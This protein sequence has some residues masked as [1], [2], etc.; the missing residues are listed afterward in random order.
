MTV[1]FMKH[2]KNNLHRSLDFL[3]PISRFQQR[4]HQISLEYYSS[5]TPTLVNSLVDDVEAHSK[6]LDD[7]FIAICV[8]RPGVYESGSSDD[9]L[10]VGDSG[11]M[12]AYW[13][14]RMALYD[15]MWRLVQADESFSTPRILA[16]LYS[17]QTAARESAAGSLSLIPYLTNPKQGAMGIGFVHGPLTLA[18]KV[19]ERLDDQDG[20]ATCMAQLQYLSVNQ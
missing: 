8:S 3:A 1:P 10:D 4:L 6:A 16:L 5:E 20:V 15:I 7:F 17:T 9:F 18:M 19:Y 2:P 14:A 12:I 13:S 11:T